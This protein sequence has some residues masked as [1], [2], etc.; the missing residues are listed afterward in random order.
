MGRRLVAGGLVALLALQGC[1]SIRQRNERF[2]YAVIPF[3]GIAATVEE[4]KEGT[5]EIRRKL[6]MFVAGG[7]FDV[8]SY[9]P[10]L[11]YNGVYKVRIQRSLAGE[12]NVVTKK[13]GPDGKMIG[14][15][16]D[17]I[18]DDFPDALRVRIR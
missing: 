3:V 16:I 5:D 2:S 9:G 6:E 12:V 14:E 1:G 11:E 15:P 17:G 10:G 18:P 13:Y 7:G 4:F 8:K